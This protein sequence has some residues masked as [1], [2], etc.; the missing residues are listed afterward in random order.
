MNP[1]PIENVK[2]RGFGQSAPSVALPTPTAP[3][4]PAMTLPSTQVMPQIAKPWDKANPFDLKTIPG[5]VN[6][7]PKPLEGATSPTGGLKSA[8]AVSFPSDK[9]PAKTGNPDLD[10]GIKESDA[11]GTD[12]KKLEGFWDKVANFFTAGGA[13]TDVT[14]WDFLEATGRAMA[15]DKGPS[16][17]QKKL[18]QAREDEL[19]KQDLASKQAQ[20][21]KDWQNQQAMANINNAAAMARIQAQIQAQQ[22]PQGMTPEMLGAQVFGGK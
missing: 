12:V 1:F 11:K 5:A 13:P 20:A 8:S 7:I 10:R 9:V 16:T 6:Q 22:N 3:T 19:I 17:R 21:A 2:P 18:D 15:R 14:I 4:N